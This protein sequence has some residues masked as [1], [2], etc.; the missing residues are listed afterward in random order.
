[1]NRRQRKKLYFRRPSPIWAPRFRPYWRRLMC[2]FGD[3]KDR[4]VATLKV[5]DCVQDCAFRE[6]AITK[7]YDEPFDR[8]LVLADGGQFSARYCCD[9]VGSPTSIERVPHHE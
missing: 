5:G 9:P 1:M 3:E 4:W 8:T 7:I 2:E 6:Q